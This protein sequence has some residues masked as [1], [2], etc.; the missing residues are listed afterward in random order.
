ML[1]WCEGSLAVS[2][3]YSDVKAV[4]VYLHV[5]VMWRQSWCIF[6]LQW[7][8]GSLGV[9]SCY[10]D[11]KVV[12]VYLHAM[13][14]ELWR[15]ESW[16]NGQC[17]RSRSFGDCS[18]PQMLKEIRWP[19][20]ELRVIGNRKGIVLTA[21]W[22]VCEWHWTCQSIWKDQQA[23]CIMTVGWQLTCI[24]R[25]WKTQN[26]NKRTIE[27]TA[28]LPWTPSAL[29]S[30]T[31]P[32]SDLVGLV[33]AAHCTFTLNPISFSQWDWAHFWLGWPSGSSSLH[34]YPEPHQL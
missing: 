23:T 31:E 2:S 11:V 14:D 21:D 33:A 34:L 9:S 25:N 22:N 12:L 5:T 24:Q 20:A 29:A 28:P 13:W 27:L 18:L 7:C 8:E 16:L 15:K 6:M 1:Q 26:E 10:S 32:T 17:C 19:F 4:L 3:C 30:E